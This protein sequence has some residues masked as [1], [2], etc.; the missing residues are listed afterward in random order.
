MFGNQQS[1]GNNNKSGPNMG[2]MMSMFADLMSNNTDNNDMPD[3]NTMKN[4]AQSMGGKQKK[5]T[6]NSFNE[7]AYRKIAAQKKLKKKLAS[8]KK[9]NNDKIDSSE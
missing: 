4:M 3:L 2:N 7:S 1:G 8:Q 9:E 5:G 6:K